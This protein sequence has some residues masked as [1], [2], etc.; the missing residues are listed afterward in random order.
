MTTLVPR[1]HRPRLATAQRGF[2]LY[3]RELRQ[4]KRIGLR[5]C[6]DAVGLVPGHLSNIENGR[7]TPPAEPI[8]IKLAELLEVSPGALLSRA[9]RLSPDHLKR[10]WESPLIPSLVMSSTGWTKEES[11]VFQASVLAAMSD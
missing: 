4:A 6:A 11:E 3:V 9:G 7:V 5:A 2:G 10:F 8:V 1:P